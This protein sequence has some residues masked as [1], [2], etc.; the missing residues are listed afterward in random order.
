MVVIVGGD[1]RISSEK[2]QQQQQSRNK[3]N[4]E[5]SLASERVRSG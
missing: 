2:K 3:L 1:L 5:R 4:T